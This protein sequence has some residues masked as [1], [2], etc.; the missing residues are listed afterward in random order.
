MKKQLSIFL[1]ILGI[2]QGTHSDQ[3][4]GQAPPAVV[5][6]AILEGPVT[7]KVSKLV[8]VSAAKSQGL[9]ILWRAINLD[10]D[11]YMLVNGD[12][13][14]VFVTSKPGIYGFEVIVSAIAAPDKIVHT[15]ATYFINV[16][17][18]AQ[19]GPNPVPVPPI[20]PT[21][22]LGDFDGLP[23]KV[24]TWAL[25]IPNSK[26]TAANLA[27]GYLEVAKG[28]KVVTFSGNPVE[29]LLYTDI[30][31]LLKLQTA[32]N[33]EV[34]GEDIEKWRNF[35]VQKLGPYLD[36]QT[37]KGKL[38]TLADYKKMEVEVSMGLK[39]ASEAQ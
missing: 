20:S 18:I 23:A 39:A 26:V 5:P 30:E 34:L 32:K 9:S 4:Y 2:F 19:Q 21:L 33:R 12:K 27:A 13:E 8:K 22:P 25:E 10:V 16:E 28:T 31:G 3:A 11:E 14:V 35:F 24:K 15:K 17:G 7:A 1:T 29:T 38:V 36:E 37:I 6:V